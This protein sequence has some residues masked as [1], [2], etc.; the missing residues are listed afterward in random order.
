[1]CKCSDLG[2]WSLS[3]SSPKV[4]W[5]GPPQLH[6]T[7]VPQ[8]VGT[9]QGKL[10]R[11]RGRS[12]VSGFSQCALLLLCLWKWAFAHR[13]SKVGRDNSRVICSNFPESTL[14]RK[15]HIPINGLEQN[16][17]HLNLA[18]YNQ[19]SNINCLSSQ[20]KKELPPLST[21]QVGRDCS[22]E[23]LCVL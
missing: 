18:F 3:P 10:E 6:M 22:L 23:L 2:Y 21:P 15:W 20:C 7:D 19:V 9:P 16:S 1:M 17:S 8:P 13:M 12:V 4:R 14:H 5:W 11:R